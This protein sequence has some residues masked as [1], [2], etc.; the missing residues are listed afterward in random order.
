MTPNEIATNISGTA[1]GMGNITASANYTH[2]FAGA[3]QQR[4]DDANTWD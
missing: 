4:M 3:N 1:A 2:T